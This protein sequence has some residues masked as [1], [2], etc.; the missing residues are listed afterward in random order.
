MNSFAYETI[1]PRDKKN[2]TVIDT[3]PCSISP[4]YGSGMIFLFGSLRG[5]VKTSI[6]ADIF[7]KN[8]SSFEIFRKYSVPPINSSSSDSMLGKNL[9]LN[10]CQ[11]CCSKN[12]HNLGIHSSKFLSGPTFRFDK[13]QL[14]FDLRPNQGERMDDRS[15]PAPR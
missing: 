4:K 15:E 12:R 10:D 1:V 11:T 3:V 6:L 5:L 9:V 13:D 8:S 14:C 7:G 2:T